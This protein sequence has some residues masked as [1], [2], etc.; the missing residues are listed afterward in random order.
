MAGP[1]FVNTV[2]DHPEPGIATA[3]AISK[4]FILSMFIMPWVGV[5]SFT[6]G[7]HSRR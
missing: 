3:V 6:H 7:H 1:N 4:T 2:G 5:F